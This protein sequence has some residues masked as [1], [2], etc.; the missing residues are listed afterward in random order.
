MSS[1]SQRFRKLQRRR[2]YLHSI[3]ENSPERLLPRRKVISIAKASHLPSSQR[4]SGKY[5]D[6]SVS[7]DDNDNEK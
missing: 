2:T 7:I 5:P 4:Q 6:H 3:V 1:I